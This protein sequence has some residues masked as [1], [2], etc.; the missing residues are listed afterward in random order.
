MAKS[1]RAQRA[2]PRTS[3]EADFIRLLRANTGRTPLHAVFS[4]FCEMA[5]LAFSNA[6]D[7]FQRERREARYMEIV[8][9]YAREEVERFP[10]MVAAL[11]LMHEDAMGDHLGRIFQALEL[12]NHWVGQFFTP[13]PVSQLMA[14]MTAGDI[15]A[16]V[17]E[18]GFITVAEPAC[19]AG[20]ML[21]A[22]ADAV[23]DQG[24]N[25]Q[26]VMHATA[27]DID[28]TAVHMAYVQCCICHI[29]AI[30]VHGNALS[31]E[32]WGHWVTPAHVL[33][34]WDGLLR[35]R[36]SVSTDPHVVHTIAGPVRV[37]QQSGQV[38]GASG[39]AVDRPAQARDLVL[40]RRAEQLGLF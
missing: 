12:S 8:R 31:L 6:V 33:G 27:I 4:D 30:L 15:A 29:P 5:A 7:L 18:Q 11:V 36:F 21:I 20:G 28:S 40:T 23:R 2:T 25:Y 38:E 17:R 26:K 3:H 13:Y 35:R 14:R 24:I 19:G 37:R 9:K 34:G 16:Q 39:E 32:E 1:A 22:F 10:Q